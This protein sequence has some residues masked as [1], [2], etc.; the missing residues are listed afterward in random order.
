[1]LLLRLFLRKGPWFRLNSLAYSE[2]NDALAAS[3]TLVGL[4]FARTTVGGVPEAELQ[5]I[6]KVPQFFDTYNLQYILCIY[7]VILIL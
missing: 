6:L 2:L 5:G 7:C 4:G 3:E 1:M